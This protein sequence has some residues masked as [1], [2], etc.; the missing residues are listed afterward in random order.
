M[1]V[2]L[3]VFIVFS[4]NGLWYAHFFF[5]ERNNIFQFLIFVNFQKIVNIH[6]MGINGRYINCVLSK[7]PIYYDKIVEKMSIMIK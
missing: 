6:L 1:Q 3:L 4:A 5:T 7:T 2:I